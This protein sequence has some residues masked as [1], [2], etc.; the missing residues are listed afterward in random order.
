ME[1]T[2][3]FV[4]QRFFLGPLLDATNFSGAV[5][6]MRYGVAQVLI[7]TAFL[8]LVKSF[9]AVVLVSHKSP[10]LFVFLAACFGRSGASVPDDEHARADEEN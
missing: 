8:T 1:V 3:N 5:A 7:H 2:E 9:T 4:E 6:A 10:S